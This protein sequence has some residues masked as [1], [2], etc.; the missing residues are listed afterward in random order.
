MYIN[1]L[2]FII[3]IIIFSCTSKNN[4]VRVINKET[5]KVYYPSGNL[6]AFY[7]LKNDSIKHGEYKIFYENGKI[8]THGYFY[9]GRKDSLEQIFYPSGDYKELMSWKKGIPWGE[10]KVFFEGL[11]E[12]YIHEVNGDTLEF[13]DQLQK[14][15]IGYNHKGKIK[16]HRAYD[17]AGNLIQEKGS[18]ILFTHLIN[19]EINLN[20]ILDIR[21]YLAAPK[22]VNSGFKVFVINN[23]EILDSIHLP[24]SKEHGAVFYSKKF[25]KEGIFKII[26]ISILEDYYNDNVKI[27]TVEHIIKVGDGI[28]I[29]I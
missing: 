21:Y 11:Y 8:K 22:W 27:D 28:E 26:G 17:S 14:E 6:K 23:N 10:K 15:Y 2:T 5:L 4:N 29:E 1:K 19:D 13:T 7:L 3:A 18:S 9:N 20:E 25:D 12:Q 16:Y 24:I